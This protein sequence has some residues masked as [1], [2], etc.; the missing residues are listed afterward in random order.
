MSLH[1]Q[2]RTMTGGTVQVPIWGKTEQI[3]Q[4]VHLYS[5]KEDIKKQASVFFANPP[6]P[7]QLYKFR[8]QPAIE[9][10]NER[11]MKYDQ[12]F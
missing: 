7:V 9:L 8:I 5:E 12:Q 11:R 10:P 4:L 1:K 2:V 6:C 3:P